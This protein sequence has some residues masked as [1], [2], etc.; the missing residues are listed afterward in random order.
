[1]EDGYLSG[2][3]LHVRWEGVK[4]L[5]SG[6]ES[7]N[8]AGLTTLTSSEPF[9]ADTSPPEGGRVWNV[10][11]DSNEHVRYV[12]DVHVQSVHWGGYHDPHTGLAYYRVGLGTSPGA[13]DIHALQYVGLQTSAGMNY[14]KSG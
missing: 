10:A 14:A 11:A 2:H 13:D 4:D 8:R 12:T 9:V 1:M 5:E 3:E 6:I 7:T